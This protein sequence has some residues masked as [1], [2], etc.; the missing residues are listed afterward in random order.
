MQFGFLLTRLKRSVLHLIALAINNRHPPINCQRCHVFTIL[1]MCGSLRFEEGLLT[2][3]VSKTFVPASSSNRN[4]SC[5]T[6][7]IQRLLKYAL[8]ADGRNSGLL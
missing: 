3:I 1:E 4:K 8:A 7:I 6:L 5:E 2:G